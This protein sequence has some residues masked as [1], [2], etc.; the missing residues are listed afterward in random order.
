MNRRVLPTVRTA[1]LLIVGM[2]VVGFVA[3][4][5]Y[6]GSTRA[7]SNNDRAA[8]RAELTEARGDLDQQK[9]ATAAQE[10]ATTALADQVESLGEKPVVEPEAAARATLVQVPGPRGPGPTMA[11]L[12]RLVSAQID[13][14]LV[15]VCG[16]SC[17][18]KT[19]KAGANGADSEI[20]GPAGP[21]GPVGP[22]G[23]G[24]S[25]GSDGSNG[26]DGSNGRG[27]ESL[28]CSTLAPET[29]FTITFTDG[30]SQTITCS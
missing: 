24:G 21:P 17:N 11:Q 18:G 2:L 19:G 7:R 25:D 23:D 14:V 22:K 15:K 29:T 6:D 20:P 3:Y 16:G 13:D 1:T 30:T 4:T 27:I 12:G 8:I 5:V 10:A 26:A 9:A 28:S